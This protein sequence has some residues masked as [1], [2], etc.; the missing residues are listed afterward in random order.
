MPSQQWGGQRIKGQQPFCDV[1]RRE[2]KK[3]SETEPYVKK[4]TVLRA[5]MGEI[6]AFRWNVQSWFSCT[7]KACPKKKKKN[8]SS[9]LLPC[10]FEKSQIKCSETEFEERMLRQ[11][12]TRRRHIRH[13][14][15]L[16]NKFQG[17]SVAPFMF[18]Y[19]H[20]AWK[21]GEVL[22][23]VHEAQ[24]EHMRRVYKRQWL[25]SFRVNADEYIHKYN[26]TKAAQLA[27]WEHEMHAQEAKRK[28]TMMMAQGREQL[29]KK[30][31]DL[32]REY[33]ERQFFHWYE[34]AS[35]RLQYM[36][37]IPYIN[38]SNI[39]DH[40]EAELN[41]YT[42]GSSGT[43]QYPLNFVGQMPMIEDSDGNVVEV[44][45]VLYD[46]HVAE[47]QQ[48]TAKVYRP[49][50]AASAD[51]EL[52]QSVVSAAS[53]DLFEESEDTYGGDAVSSTVNDVTDLETQLET[54]KKT[55]KSMEDTE[56]DVRIARRN[57]IQ[58]GKQG[59]KS[60]FRRPKVDLDA[61]SSSAA[62]SGSSDANVPKLRKIKKTSEG[63][64]ALLDRMRAM[65]EGGKL[66]IREASVK[67]ALMS[68]EFKNPKVLLEMSSER[69]I[70][71][72]G[73]S[74]LKNLKAE[75]KKRKGGSDSESKNF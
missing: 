75:D 37:R 50:V 64:K 4:K 29:R 40:I 12:A 61:P 69:A 57:Y 8:I 49:G 7:R 71:S 60:P 14:N 22:R 10:P 45:E 67:S 51:V 11:T 5:N 39:A 9:L 27:E 62:P 26:I 18:P 68:E 58:R 48:S 35:E 44:P 6:A 32:L 56:D 34:R 74:A 21:Q 20:W 70:A 16:A 53:R 47:R 25:D 65:T 54:E 38:Q 24:F 3:V 23:Q 43:K 28:E 17:H 31:V 30:H 72:A 1:R 36:T 33:H 66:S 15:N 59:S 13:F 73:R 2:R 46:Q 52:Q 63:E 41:K 55:A 42:M 19:R